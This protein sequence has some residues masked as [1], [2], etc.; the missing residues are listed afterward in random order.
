M[1]TYMIVG[2]LILA[3]SVCMPAPVSA[4]DGRVE[5]GCANDYLAYCSRHDP[6]GRAVRRCMRANQRKLSQACVSALVAA[7][8]SKSSAVCPSGR[9]RR[10]RVPRKGSDRYGAIAWVNG[11]SGLAPE[12]F[13]TR[14]SAR[15]FAE[16]TISG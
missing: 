1:Q 8:Y 11:S 7:S 4:V 16:R 3:T 6:D 14:A 5:V 12:A 9:N 13:H 10:A 15:S 2:S